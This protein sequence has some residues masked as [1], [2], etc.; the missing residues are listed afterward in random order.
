MVFG[1]HVVD[2]RLT[3][4]Q[5]KIGF[6]S[7]WFAFASVLFLLNFYRKRRTFLT[8]PEFR[9]WKAGVLVLA[10]ICGGVFTAFSGSGLDIC[11]FAI[12]T[13]LFRVSEKTATPTSVVLMAGNSII[14]FYWRGVMMR[15]ITDETWQ[16]FAVCVPVVVIGAPLGSFLGSHFHRLVLAT[17]VCLLELAALLGAYA[18]VDLTKGLVIASFLIIGLGMGL[19]VLIALAGQAVLREIVNRETEQGNKKRSTDINDKRFVMDAKI[20]GVDN[21]AHSYLALNW[22]EVVTNKTSP[23]LYN[24][25]QWITHIKWN[26]REN[27]QKFLLKNYEEYLSALSF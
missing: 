21:K 4:A 27:L 5:K 8:I 1:L 20:A 2:P 16:Y 13:L 11:T 18:L 26:S 7:I 19:F 25:I 15:A 17:L 10:G 14:G 23:S 24:N 22:F 6:V 12:L 3:A 9:A